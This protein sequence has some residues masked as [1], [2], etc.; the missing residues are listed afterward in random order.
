MRSPGPGPGPGHLSRKNLRHRS[1]NITQPSPNGDSDKDRDS[2]HPCQSLI[3]LAD[4]RARSACSGF[5]NIIHR[6][7][8][9]AA[10]VCDGKAW[11]GSLAGID[12][13]EF[14]AVVQIEVEVEVER[15]P[16]PIQIPLPLSPASLRLRQPCTLYLPF[17]VH[18]VDLEL[19]YMAAMPL[20]QSQLTTATEAESHCGIAKHVAGAA[21]L[22]PKTPVLSH[23]LKHDK[24]I[25]ALVVSADCIFAGTEGGEILVDKRQLSGNIASANLTSRSITSRPTNESL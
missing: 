2:N 11:K 19:Y 5:H 13:G 22:R 12:G 14:D 20:T 4:W 21:E 25:L 17:E 18:H 23:R 8:N 7:S 1:S 3:P 16:E 24:S 15:V 10:M 6:Q 9:P